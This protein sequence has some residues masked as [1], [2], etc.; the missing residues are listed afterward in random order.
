[1]MSKRNDLMY[2]IKFETVL[3]RDALSKHLLMKRT[4]DID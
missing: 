2:L 1:M 3:R 4:A